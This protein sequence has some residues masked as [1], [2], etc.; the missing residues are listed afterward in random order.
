MKEPFPTHGKGFFLY[1]GSLIS[2]LGP[3]RLPPALN[4][5]WEDLKTAVEIIAEEAE[6]A[7]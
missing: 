7:I 3:I 1:V 5:P 2:A 6:R 4:I